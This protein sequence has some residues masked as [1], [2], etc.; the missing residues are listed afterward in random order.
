[1]QPLLALDSFRQDLVYAARSLR[2]SP[3]LVATVA[4]S[5]GLGIGVNTTVFNLFNITLLAKP[6]AVEPDR[7]VAI[8]PGNGNRI[9]YPNY[10]DLG[11]NSSLAGMAVTTM[12]TVSLRDQNRIENV[13]ALET[14]A[15]YFQLLGAGAALGRTFSPGDEQSAVLGYTFWQKRF[16][17]DP[18]VLGRSFYWNGHPLTVGGIMSRDYRPG[19]G[20]VAPDVYLPVSATLLPFSLDRRQAHFSLLARLAPGVTR[21]QAQA[22]FTALARPLEQAYPEDNQSFG[23]PPSVLPAYGIGSFGGHGWDAEALV[24]FGAPF[25]VTGILLLIACAN[26]AGV[27]LAR[28]SMRR[29][30][31]AIRLALGASRRRLAQI[32]LAETLLLSV[33]GAAAGLLLTAWITPLLSLVRVPNTPAFAPFALRIDSN[34]A[35]YALGTA[36]ATC[37]ACG[38]SPALQSVRTSL[39]P[40]LKQTALSGRG[41]MRR[42]LVAAQVAG[43][44]LLLMTCALFLRS[45]MYLGNINPGIDVEHGITAKIT[46]EQNWTQTQ[47]YQAANELAERVAAVPGVRS[48]SY[49]SLIPLGGDS[50]AN[51]VV[52]KDAFE[53]QP[54]SDSPVVLTS[55]VGP[56]YFATMGI[57]ILRGR[58]FANAD[59]QG[60]PLVAI[61][62]RAFA[63]RFFPDGAALGKFMGLGSAKKHGPWREIVGI[64]A[65]NDYRFMGER[66][67]PQFFLPFLQSDG[68]VFLQVSAYRD[69]AATVAAVQRAIV[70]RDSSLQ[71]D[72][73][74]TR[75]ATSLELTLRRFAT[76]LLAAMGSLGLLLAMTGL[77]GV[78]SWEVSRRTAEIGI[79]MALGASASSVRRMVL[80]SSLAIT[81]AGIAVGGGAAMLLAIPL[82]P[83]LKGAGPADAIAI[84]TVAA[85]L[86]LV[87]IAASWSPVRRASRIDPI[88]AL[89]YE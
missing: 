43:S 79:R 78:L 4:I 47:A 42:F 54:G 50:V 85:A 63:A 13:L 34:L 14:S 72:V 80:R 44:V 32:L 6:T 65:N 33:A 37:A 57:R 66:P 2:K 30:E 40:G 84:F 75:Q 9:S 27:M 24:S 49:A 31:I 64:A 29:R 89:R 12:G 19:T 26:V 1:M 39:L 11:A 41:P 67:E 62:N 45:L 10:Q 5:L 60:A 61:V 74:T 21:P 81:A 70:E 3:G 28:G 59:R 52:V 86:C 68:R 53:G 69:P 48:V 25:L 35:L 8:E 22:A 87:S 23:H 71:A 17:G 51:G 38:I 20:A 15:N 56:R 7:L 88:S 83:V 46:P 76:L 82:S 18:G 73:Q 36:L 77:Y 58:E 55:N 16:Q